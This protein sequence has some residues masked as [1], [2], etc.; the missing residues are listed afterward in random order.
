MYHLQTIAEFLDQARSV[1]TASTVSTLPAPSLSPAT[2]E[3]KALSDQLT[4]LVHLPTVDPNF[5]FLSARSSAELAQKRQSPAGEFIRDR[6]TALRGYIAEAER[7]AARKAQT[8][9]GADSF[10]QRTVQFLKQKLSANQLLQEIYEGQ[11][12][13]EREAGFFEASK[14][15]WGESLPEVFDKLEEGMKGP[16]A[17]GD[18]VV[19]TAAIPLTR[20]Y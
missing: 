15:A 13:A 3:G 17:L 11:A 12:G 2:I 9:P 18:Q 6:Q 7:A 20:S 19:S 1:H 16:Y 4:S 5:L 8:A 10:E 14:K